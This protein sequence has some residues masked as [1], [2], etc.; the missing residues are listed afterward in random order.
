MK[1]STGS[2]AFTISI[3]TLGVLRLRQNSSIVPV[4]IMVLPLP[5]PC[6]TNSVTRATVRLNTATVKPREA[7]LRTRFSPITA[8]P[9][10]PT[11]ATPAVAACEFQETKRV[12]CAHASF[13]FISRSVCVN[14]YMCVQVNVCVYVRVSLN[15]GGRDPQVQKKKVKRSFC[16]LHFGSKRRVRNVRGNDTETTGT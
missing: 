3:T 6:S 13:I 14:T 9:T 4:P 10:R 8:R 15:F 2:P 5:R 11:S 1:A 16:H 12:S 7:R